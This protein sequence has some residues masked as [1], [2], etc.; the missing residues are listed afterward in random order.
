MLSKSASG[1]FCRDSSIAPHGTS[2]LPH[3]IPKYKSTRR[4]SRSGTSW[5]SEFHR[6]PKGA[7]SCCHARCLACR[8]R[9]H[10]RRGLSVPRQSCR[11]WTATPATKRSRTN[12]SSSLV[13]LATDRG[14]CVTITSSAESRISSSPAP[15]RSRNGSKA[16]TGS[17]A[18][19]KGRLANGFLANLGRSCSQCRMSLSCS[20]SGYAQ[21]STPYPHAYFSCMPETPW[22]A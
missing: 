5:C 16:K 7:A 21:S 2:S 10:R 20:Q 19:T 3:M 9:S 6:Q 17:Q 12:D 18:K 22:L 14:L 4:S 15:R 13:L 8:S 1:S 11:K